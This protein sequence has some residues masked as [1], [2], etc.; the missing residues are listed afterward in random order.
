MSKSNADQ[1]LFLALSQRNL[2]GALHAVRNGADASITSDRR[3]DYPTVL[4]LAI[5]RGDVDA[6]RFLIDQGVDL[7]PSGNLDKDPLQRTALHDVAGHSF[8]SNSVDIARLL[9]GKGLDVNA[10]DSF[11]ITPLHRAVNGNN[12]EF[13]SY[14]VSQGADVNAAD[15]IH[16]TPL[17]EAVILN[18]PRMVTSLLEH[19]ADINAGRDSAQTALHTACSC[20]DEKIVRLLLDNGAD[21]HARDKKG[22]TPLHAI[23]YDE[24]GIKR[25]DL[26]VARLLIERGVELDAKDKDGLTAREIAEQRGCT[27]LASLLREAEFRQLSHADR[28]ARRSDGRSLSGPGGL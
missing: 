26:A 24:I 25:P 7:G 21:I 5:E 15:S 28:E 11:G 27:K 4:E 23:V 17:Q 2:D 10:R 12:P 6:V 22:Q 20:N 8:K 1:K 16:H 3:S 14:L 13:I 9:I 18:E 19:G